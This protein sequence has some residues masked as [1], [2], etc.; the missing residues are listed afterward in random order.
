MA[1]PIQITM[2]GQQPTPPYQS[3]TWTVWNDID[4][5]GAHSGFGAG[6]LL[7]VGA[8]AVA[9]VGS[10][11]NP[12]TFAVGGDLAGLLP[13]PSVA[14]LQGQPV[15][16]TAP[17]AGQALVFDGTAWAPA[18]APASVYYVAF[19][20]DSGSVTL[21]A[22]SWGTTPTFTYSAVGVYLVAS[23]GAVIPQGAAWCNYANAAA[24]PA[25]GLIPSATPLNPVHP[26]S[27]SVALWGSVSQ[28][29]ADPAD[30]DDIVTVFFLA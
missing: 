25:I 15:S 21:F 13:N 30:P 1:V 5:T 7:N 26:E 18:A 4:L 22:T 27:I 9:A 2:T 24:G 16:V 28:A 8:V 19:K 17:T 29:P 20:V 23:P 3:V 12:L 6:V 10:P 11:V 14:G